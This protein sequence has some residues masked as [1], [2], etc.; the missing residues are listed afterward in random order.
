V[1]LAHCPGVVWPVRVATAAAKFKIKNASKKEPHRACSEYTCHKDESYSTRGTSTRWL[2]GEGLEVEVEEML[3][4][5]G[6]ES[7]NEE[8]Q[9]DVVD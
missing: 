3:R 9:P 2:G 7:A 4:V 8:S 1:E 5:S 6:A